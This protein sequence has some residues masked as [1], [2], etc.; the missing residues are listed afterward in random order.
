MVRNAFGISLLSCYYETE[1]DFRNVMLCKLQFNNKALS[2][3]VSL[4]RE[5][6]ENNVDHCGNFELMQNLLSLLCERSLKHTSDSTSS[7]F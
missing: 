7:R 6:R 3:Q 1:F 4:I 2:G 5:K